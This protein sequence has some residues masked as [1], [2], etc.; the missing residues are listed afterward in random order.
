M[1]ISAP[2]AAVRNRPVPGAGPR[3]PVR[4]PAIPRAEALADVEHALL[5]QPNLLGDL[6]VYQAAFPQPDDRATTILLSRRRQAPHVHVHHQTDLGPAPDQSKTAQA[7]S[8][9]KDPVV[10]HRRV[11]RN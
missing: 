6:R 9:S 8:I 5:G 7:G 2:C 11:N 3:G 4:N 1:R 10:R